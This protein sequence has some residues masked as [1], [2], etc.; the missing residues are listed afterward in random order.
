MP[1]HL[2]GPWSPL[3][4]RL[5]LSA[6]PYNSAILI[7]AFAFSVIAGLAIVIPTLYYKK[8][9]YIFRE[10]LTTVDHKK[11]GVMYILL[12]LVMMFR[13]FA[14]GFMIRTQQVM[15]DGPHSL[16]YMGS[17]HGYLPPFHFD[18]IYSS[19]GTIIDRKSVV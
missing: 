15:A 12:G 16:G 9:G 4:G 1:V 6:I 8:V 11:I 2:Q 14:D 3:F 17:L 5:T 7:G 18:Q 19:H 13:G 10:W